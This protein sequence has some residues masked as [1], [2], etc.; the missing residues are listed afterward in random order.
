M[1][2][3]IESKIKTASEGLF[4]VVSQ[5]KPAYPGKPFTL[6]GRLVVDL[7]EVV[8][9]LAYEL[10]LNEGLTKH[11]DAVCDEGRDVQIKTTFGTSLTLL[12]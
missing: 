8:A 9:S 12:V 5:L 3:K 1:D 11:H 10:T 4:A 2:P 7:G 6:D